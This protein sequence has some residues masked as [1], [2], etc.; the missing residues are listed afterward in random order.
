MQ[1]RIAIIGSG[2]WATALSKLFLNN[3]GSI[4]WFIRNQA[5]IDIL[6]SLQ[7]IP[8]IYNLLNL[9]LIKLIFITLL[10]TVFSI[11]IL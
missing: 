4:N 8:S 2:S 1:T 5:D 3:C 11:R 10:K 6:K 9:R 7:T